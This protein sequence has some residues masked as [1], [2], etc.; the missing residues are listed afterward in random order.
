MSLAVLGLL[1]VLVV[2]SASARLARAATLHF[3]RASK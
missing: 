3:A 2:L 1:A